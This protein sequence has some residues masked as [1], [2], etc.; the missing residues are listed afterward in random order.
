MD[1]ERAGLRIAAGPSINEQ[2][3]CHPRNV[4]HLPD[5]VDP[6]DVCPPN[7]RNGNGRRGAHHSIILRM[8]S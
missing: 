2:G 1:L 5:V 7:Y 6:N 8:V 3:V 4:Y